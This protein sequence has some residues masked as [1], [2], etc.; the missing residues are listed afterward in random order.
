MLGEANEAVASGPP[1][2]KYLILAYFDVNVN[3]GIIMKLGQKVGN[4]SSIRSEKLFFLEITMIWE[5]KGKYEIKAIFF[6]RTSSFRNPCLGP[7]TLNIHHC[8][9]ETTNNTYPTPRIQLRKYL[10]E[11]LTMTVLPSNILDFWKE[12]FEE[13]SPLSKVANH[14]LSVPASSAPVERIFSAGGLIMRP[15]RARLSCNMLGML[16][17]LKCNFEFLEK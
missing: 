7:L 6:L 3:L 14:A 4:W 13:Y 17:Y 12:K 2:R 9:R 8:K 10:E 1:P 5:K 16:V 15:H 11:V